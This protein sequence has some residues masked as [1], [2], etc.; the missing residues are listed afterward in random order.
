MVKK[1]ATT[2]TVIPP[3]ARTEERMVAAAWLSQAPKSPLR[4]PKMLFI[5]DILLNCKLG[6]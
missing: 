6:V 4:E 1:K 2:D 5:N 3:A